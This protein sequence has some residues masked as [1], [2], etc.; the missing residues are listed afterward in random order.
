[1]TFLTELERLK[2]AKEHTPQSAYQLERLLVNH[3]DALAELVR[4]AEL[5][6]EVQDEPCRWDNDGYCQSHN[7]DHQLDGCRVCLLKE[8][9]A[10]LNGAEK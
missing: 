5:C 6:A 4:A 10:K 3:A 8:A 1:M 7:M 2:G 9:L